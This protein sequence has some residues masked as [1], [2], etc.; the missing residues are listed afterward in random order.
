MKDVKNPEAVNPGK[1]YPREK[2]MELL[3]KSENK[4]ES[5]VRSSS[6][7]EMGKRFFTHPF[8]GKITLFEW[9][10]IMALHELRHLKI[11]QQRFN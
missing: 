2:I 11:L 6:R 8:Y 1:N 5:L 9:I 3:D 4:L 7:E 10:W